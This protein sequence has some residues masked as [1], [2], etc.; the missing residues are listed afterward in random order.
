MDENLRALL[1]LDR[2]QILIKLCSSENGL[3]VA[4]VRKRR[5]EF[6]NNE[7]VKKYYH[8]VISEA[9]SHS[10]NPL[11]AILLFA[12]IVSAFTK[13]I[14]NAL[15]I[16]IIILMSII[17]AYIQTHRSLAAVKKL[18]N[19]VATTVD[20]I[21]DGEWIEIPCC[22]LV[23]G[24]VM[25]LAA[26][27]MVPADALV[28][29]A[30]DL[31]VQ[32]AALTGESLPVEKEPIGAETDPDYLSDAKNVVFSGSSVVSGT[33]TAVVFAT[34]KN[35]L[36]GQIA[37]S[38]SMTPPRT[39]F[40]KGML[41]FG[42]FVMK[43]VIF[44]VFAVFIIN[45]YLDRSPIESLL[46]SIALAVGLTPELL[47]MITTVTLATGAVRMA[48]K[49]VI[50]KNLSAIQNFGSI[51][52]L[53]SDKTGTL[54]SGEMVLEKHI[55]IF[56]KPSEYVMLLAYLNSLYGTEFINPFNIAVLKKAN[57]NP[58]D[59]AILK[60]DHPDIQTYLKIDEIPFDFERRCSSVVVD[61]N[62]EHYL[63]TKGAPE[64]ILDKCTSYV[65]EGVIKSIDES[66]YS[67]CQRIF[68][69][70]SNSGYRILA[71]SYR[72][73]NPQSSYGTNDEADLTLAG[74]LAFIDPPLDDAAIM[75]KEMQREGVAIKILTGDNDL[76]A[77]HICKQVG[78]D[79]SRIITGQELE[80]MT[81]PALAVQAEHTQVFARITPAQKQRIISALRSRGHVVGYIGDGINDAPSLHTADVGISVSHAVD[82]ARDAASIILLKQNLEILLNGII[83]GRKSFGN[84]I[85]YLIVGTSSNFGN[86]LSMIIALVFIPFLPAT[87]SQLLLNNLLYDISQ[88]TIPTDN[89]DS[90]FTRKP[91]NWNI[92]IIKQ[93]MFYLG[94]L[95]SLFDLITFFVMLQVFQASEI[96]FQTGWF[97]ES[98]LTQVLVILVVR[99][100]KSCWQS[101][102]SKPLLA[103]VFSIA[104]IGIIMPYFN[105][106]AA[107]FHFTALPP[108]YFIFLVLATTVFLYLMEVTKKKL[109]WKWI[110][111]GL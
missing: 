25:R 76:V 93:F 62:G 26:G 35:T 82:V 11:V 104:V 30:K 83:E 29:H 51:D 81:D 19:Q 86:M 42:L 90:S 27:D 91:R 110:E 24:D 101:R 32:Q 105:P 39:E 80:H 72:K 36:F 60:H 31:H 87:P 106:I 109:M 107:L 45:I 41:R 48:K 69:T 73:M 14:I 23:P 12:A 85:K 5:Q 20:V 46:F 37:Q 71:V 22:E 34:G 78:L 28:L 18:Q 88:I 89:V 47:P 57:I 33:A 108:A 98:L 55:N 99:T 74:F 52:I 64:G 10:F 49:N 111:Q 1:K 54:T 77:N 53:C 84:V 79:P 13:N 7:I 96:L 59:A 38:L 3:T 2:D 92:D 75:I 9:I 68:H 97:V 103:S 100:V 94:P 63:I 50:V 56:G 16:I 95:T 44:L 8:S 102:P 67:Q 40:D 43:T 65:I 21:R 58:L 70:L 17:L 6:G 4:E 66:V 15:I 61:K